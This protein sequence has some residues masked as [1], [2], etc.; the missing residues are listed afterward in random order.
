MAGS[1]AYKHMLGPTVQT[2]GRIQDRGFYAVTASV[3]QLD[4]LAPLNPARDLRVSGHVIY[5]GRSSMEVAV[6]IESI[7]LG[8][9]DETVLIAASCRDAHTHKARFVNPLTMSTPEE[10]SL[11]AISERTFGPSPHFNYHPYGL[12]CAPIDLKERRASSAL[13]SLS[14]VPPSSAEAE[15]L[16]SFHLRNGHGPPGLTH[17]A[18]AL[19][20]E[21]KVWIGD[22]TLENCMIMFPQ[23]R[24]CVVHFFYICFAAIHER[25]CA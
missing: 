11:H 9:P 12:T 10:R 20:E 13:R 7:G 15:A 4:M 1:T 21:Q 18:N 8:L 22:T 19:E 23:E 6:R 5:T 14:L 16:H 3:D 17:D 24:K 2:M 25:V